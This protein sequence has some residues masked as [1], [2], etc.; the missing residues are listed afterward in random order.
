MTCAVSSTERPAKYR[1]STI[2]LSTFVQARQAFQR[3]VERDDVGRA[4]HGRDFRV[5]QPT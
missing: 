2:R 4:F 3:F 5:T 1:S